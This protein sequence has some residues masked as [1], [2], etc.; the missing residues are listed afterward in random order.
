[1]TDKIRLTFGDSLSY[2]HVRRIRSTLRD[3]GLCILPSDTGYS[4]AGLPFRRTVVSNIRSILG[5]ADQPIPL[6]FGSLKQVERFVNLTPED[7]RVIDKYCPGPVTLVCE[8]RKDL[9]DPTANG[10]SETLHT[11]GTV[12]VRIPDSP[13]ERQICI[14]IDGPLT[15]AAIRYPASEAIVQDF[16][17]AFDLV[18]SR[19]KAIEIGCLVVGIKMARIKY[20]DHSTVVTVE[21]N[22][23]APYVIREYRPGVV[24]TSEIQDTIRRLSWSDFEDWT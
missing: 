24:G 22:L 14:E 2:E 4:L 16:D 23:A 13:V 1:M 15:T 7:E 10:I 3:G 21:P 19:M 11:V 8:L 12:G 9:A 6:A 5:K 20:S 18:L 17:D